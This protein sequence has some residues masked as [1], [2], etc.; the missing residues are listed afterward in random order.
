MA[1]GESTHTPVSAPGSL[2][3]DGA[4]RRSTVLRERHLRTE[5]DPSFGHGELA[6]LGNNLF[7]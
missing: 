7:P 3:L 4:A 2:C 5:P 1:L 6:F